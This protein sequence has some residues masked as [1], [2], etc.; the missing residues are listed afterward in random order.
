[1]ALRTNAILKKY[2]S[3]I[4]GTSPKY[5]Q[6]G[7]EVTIVINRE[8]GKVYCLEES[9]ETSKMGI[10]IIILG[11]VVL[12]GIIGGLVNDLSRGI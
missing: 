3:Q 7:K 11:V 12:I 10:Y 9:R 1:M 4:G 5:K 2:K 8:N 6:V